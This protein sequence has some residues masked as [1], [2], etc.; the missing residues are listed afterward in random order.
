MASS[1]Y[2][3]DNQVWRNNMSEQKKRGQ[4]QI[5]R[6]HEPI[7]GIRKKSKE[8]IDYGV[9]KKQFF[10]VLEKVSQPVKKSESDSGKAQT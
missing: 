4:K 2:S 10:A 8:P 3:L 1:H 9:T 7:G 6:R 5:G